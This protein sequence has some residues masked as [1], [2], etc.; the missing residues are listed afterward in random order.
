MT[1]PEELIEI[2]KENEETIDHIVSENMQLTIED[3]K[4]EVEKLLKFPHECKIDA[5]ELEKAV[6]CNPKECEHII[7][8]LE[9][10]EFSIRNLQTKIDSEHF[11]GPTVDLLETIVTL[12]KSVGVPDEII[13]VSPEYILEA[14]KVARLRTGK[15]SLQNIEKRIQR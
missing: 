2:D 11:D 12:L 14:K 8:W 4:K 5:T 1:T 7:F 6:A 10:D 3:R 13:K 9:T 15:Y